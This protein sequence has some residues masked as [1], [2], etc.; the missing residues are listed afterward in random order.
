MS[1]WRSA[2]AIAL[3]LGAMALVSDIFTL[4]EAVPVLVGP[5]CA[6]ARRQQFAR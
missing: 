3:A 1:Y 6:T 5:D 2:A 4:I